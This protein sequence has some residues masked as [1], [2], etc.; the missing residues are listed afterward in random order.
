MAR[1]PTERLAAAPDAP[2]LA[3]ARRP[4]IYYGYWLVVVAFIAQFVSVGAQNYVFGPFFK[5]MTDDLG[6]TRSEYTLARTLGQFVFAFAGLMIGA[7]VDRHGGRR[8]M[9]VGV[10]IL[11]ASMVA[12]SYV[13][14]LWQWWLLNGLALTAGAAMMGNLVVN[15]TLAKWFVEKRGR[16]AGFASMGVSFAGVAL[17]PFATVLIDEV[18]WRAAWRLLALGAAAIIVPLSFAM[19]RAPEDYGLQPDGKSAEE[20]AAGGGQRAAADLASSMT[21]RQAMRTSSFYLVVFAFGLGGLSIGMM[22]VQTIPFMTDAGY[23][24]AVAALM[25]TVASVPAMVTKPVWGY[26]IDRADAQRLSNVG[27]VLTAAAM[28]LIVVSVR[29]RIDPLVYV[30]FFLLGTGWGGFIP[31]QE[32]VW[33]TF[34]GR[35][36][37]GAVRSAGMP[38]ALLLS[39][40]APLLASLYFDQVGNYDGAFLAVAAFSLVAV[41]LISLARRPSRAAA[42]GVGGMP[43]PSARA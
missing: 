10:A 5:P 6:W 2:A 33:A 26:F 9:R 27:F 32:V 24:R 23:S 30:A 1:Q 8:L 39:A 21:R 42:E 14:E 20:I 18:G 19:R 4:R 16:A 36:Y 28:A 35:R 31:L 29:A 17:T 25:I 13:T 40:S 34:F 11:V 38:F 3:A 43:A 37:L 41:L 7:Y 12:C 22:L 15:V